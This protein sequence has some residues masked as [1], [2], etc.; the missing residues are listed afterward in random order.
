MAR[1]GLRRPRILSTA[2]VVSMALGALFGAGPAAAAST[3]VVPNTAPSWVAKA[4]KVGK[5]A[6]TA[7]VQARVYLAPQG[8]ISTIAALATSIS[9]PGSADYRQF[10]SAAQYTARYAPPRRPSRRSA[11]TSRATT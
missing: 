8:G 2:V 1:S 3:A 11:T 5:A 9:T 6:P 4:P 10:L 7:R